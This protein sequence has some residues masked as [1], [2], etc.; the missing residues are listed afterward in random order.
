[1]KK[2]VAGTIK[3]MADAEA[4]ASSADADFPG[5]GIVLRGKTKGGRR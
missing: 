5:G 2:K 4:A 1:M 3:G